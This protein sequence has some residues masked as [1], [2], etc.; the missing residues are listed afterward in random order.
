MHSQLSE[1]LSGMSMESLVI[2]ALGLMNS[3][4]LKMMLL[5]PWYKEGR[6]TIFKSLYMF[7][8]F[9]II[10]TGFKKSLQN[11]VFLLP[12]QPFPRLCN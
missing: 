6:T 3:A 4:R 12:Y 11:L 10:Q 9:L 2:M 7:S 8:R 1:Q 5:F